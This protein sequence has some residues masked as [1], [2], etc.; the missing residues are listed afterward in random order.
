[1]NIIVTI[2]HVAYA[3]WRFSVVRVDEHP[4]NEVVAN[5]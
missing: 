5:G 3:G 2:S 4:I 1:M